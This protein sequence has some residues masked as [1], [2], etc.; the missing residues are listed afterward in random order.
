MAP[1]QG[2][3]S[4]AVIIGGGA[5]TVLQCGQQGQPACPTPEPGNMVLVASAGLALLGLHRHRQSK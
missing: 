4:R 1:D 3:T 2:G 5:G